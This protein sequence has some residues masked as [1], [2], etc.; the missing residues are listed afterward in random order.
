MAIKLN[1]EKVYESEFLW[2]SKMRE[3][4]I[5]E[6]MEM[7]ATAWPSVKSEAIAKC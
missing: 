2:S 7:I 1:L 3:S 4:D 5:L 6:A